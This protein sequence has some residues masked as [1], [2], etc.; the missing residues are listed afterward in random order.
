M[1]VGPAL[2][3]CLLLNPLPFA[4]LAFVFTPSRAVLVALLAIAAAKAVLESYAAHALRPGGVSWLAVASMPLKDLLLLW[5]WVVGLLRSEV[6]WRGRRLAVT[7]GTR[8]VPIGAV[9]DAVLARRDPVTAGSR[10]G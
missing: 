8:L 9:D 3:A 6:C 4:L 7:E 10:A 1:S 2:Y 5:A